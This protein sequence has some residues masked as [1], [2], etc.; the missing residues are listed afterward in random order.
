[1]RIKCIPITKEIEGGMF[2][3]SNSKRGTKSYET[4]VLRVAVCMDIVRRIAL[5]I[6]KPLVDLQ[7]TD[8]NDIHAVAGLDEPD[9]L[10]TA[11]TSAIKKPYTVSET[12]P[13][14]GV[15][16]R[17]VSCIAASSYELISVAVLMDAHA[18]V[19]TS[20]RLPPAP[21]AATLHTSC[22][23]DVHLVASV[24]VC[25]IRAAH[26][27]P[28][29]NMP[30]MLTTLDT[31]SIPAFVDLLASSVCP[32]LLR[33]YDRSCEA[34]LD[35]IPTV[36]ATRSEPDSEGLDLQLTTLID[37]HALDMHAVAPARIPALTSL[38]PYPLPITI[39]TWPP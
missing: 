27:C 12:E 28:P 5:L 7:L 4:A 2:L 14:V 35:V 34:V 18:P 11:E 15:F 37:H 29:T 8:D 9:T 6:P 22:V 31:A 33:S 26:V 24:P 16:P 38:P 13:V 19:T 30:A 1:M 39:T 25:P 17:V 3:R 21:P 32:R 36:R 20:A 23:P 10:R